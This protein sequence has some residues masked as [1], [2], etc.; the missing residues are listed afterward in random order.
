MNALFRML[1][2]LIPLFA[3][4][5]VLAA[6]AVLHILR[7]PRYRFGSRGFWLAV[8]VVFLLVEPVLYFAAGRGET[9]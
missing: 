4:D 9:P 5:A 7:H 2:L 8:A 1:P 6:A 3:V